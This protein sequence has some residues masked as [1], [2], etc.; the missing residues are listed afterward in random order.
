MPHLKT[1]IVLDGKAGNL[2]LG[3]EI[4]QF[5]F[6]GLTIQIKAK[7]ISEDYF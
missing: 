6:N 2:I 7:F 4:D 3:K 1:E 5:T